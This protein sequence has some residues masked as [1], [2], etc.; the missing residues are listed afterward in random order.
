MLSWEERYNLGLLD[1]D[2]TMNPRCD[3]TANFL[4]R[5]LQKATDSDRFH[6]EAILG[7]PGF[8]ASE[9]LGQPTCVI[10][11]HASTGIRVN[12]QCRSDKQV[13]MESMPS[14]WLILSHVFIVE[15]NPLQVSI[16]D[17][18]VIYDLASS[19]K[20]SI[21]SLEM[22]CG[23][24][25]GWSYGMSFLRKQFQ[26]PF[27]RTVAID[28][29][30]L[31]VHNWILNH[32]GSYIESTQL[33]PWQLPEVLPGNIAIVAS[34]HDLHWRQCIAL[35]KPD[36]FTL[37]APCVSWTGAHNQ[38][39]LFAAGGLVFSECIQ[40]AKFIRPRALLIEQVKNF[41]SHEHFPKV[42]RLLSAAGFRLIFRQVLEAANTSPMF[43]A[44][45]IGIAVD[46]FSND[47]FD[48]G[49][50]HTRW[51]GDMYFHPASFECMV[52]LTDT[53][54]QSMMLSSSTQ[55]KYF[56][57]NLAPKAFKNK[58]LQKRSPNVF[59]QMPTLMAAYGRQHCFNEAD[60]RRH[61]LYGHLLKVT[62]EAHSDQLT[63]RFWHPKEL[64]LMFGVHEAICLLKPADRS[65]QNLGNAI[66]TNHAVFALTAVAPLLLHNSP[67]VDTIQALQTHLVKRLRNSRISTEN[68]STCWILSLPEVANEKAT[69]VLEFFRIV[70]QEVGSLPTATIYHPQIGLRKFADI[71]QMWYN[72]PGIP[73]QIDISP[74]QRDW[75]KLQV[76]INDQVFEGASIH[77]D[78]LVD[79]VTKMWDQYAIPAIADTHQHDFPENLHFQ[80]LWIGEK[81]DVP[82]DFSEIDH[83]TPAMVYIEE[84]AWIV[85]KPYGMV[86]E[87][88]LTE[89]G[90]SQPFYLPMGEVT[91]N[92]TLQAPTVLFAKLPTLQILTGEIFP[93]VAS[94]GLT[95]IWFTYKCKTDD[96]ILQIDLSTIDPSILPK[97]KNFGIM[98]YHH[99]NGCSV[100]VE[101]CNAQREIESCAY[102]FR[103]P[104]P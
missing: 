39:G 34:V 1:Y 42:I 59:E 26:F 75:L 15:S 53:E 88:L 14:T 83:L 101:Q 55:A 45:W 20:H 27:S 24:F 85:A 48:L 19:K 6:F 43:R 25:G 22:C 91:R 3:T 8:V 70:K 47:P 10:E 30:H 44:R 96:T 56:D 99:R 95:K 76:R 51:M 35:L 68:H 77:I 89:T 16:D 100:M 97:A 104:Q 74:T 46:V 50:L 60:L 78:A 52:E 62:G 61:G 41:P 33:L 57:P 17:T 23:G 98:Q 37:S 49:L 90:I 12:I 18:T 92:R 80:Q 66:A 79:T 84:Q 9:L 64:A 28:H 102:D 72:P 13:M 93:F 11:A 73:L 38:A 94:I 4:I 65:W 71:V 63:F 69:Q 86:L 87:H 103:Q 54:K 58:L 7:K 67:S 82:M 40:L 31:A 21:V 2:I 36:L 29:D 5:D 32:Q 81:P